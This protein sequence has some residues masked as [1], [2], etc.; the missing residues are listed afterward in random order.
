MLSP[1]QLVF[2][3]FTSAPEGSV[4]TRHEIKNALSAFP[5]G[6]IN[7]AVTNLQRARK[8]L[9]VGCGGYYEL[10]EGA[11]RP[12]NDAALI[13]YHDLS[14]RGFQAVELRRNSKLFE[15]QK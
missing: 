5:P 2:D 1:Q 10:N 13:D 14:S 8:I 9:R 6:H 4:F 12:A 7:G 11:T 15:E 3:F